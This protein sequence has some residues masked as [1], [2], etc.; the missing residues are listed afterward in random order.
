MAK[1]ACCVVVVLAA[2]ASLGAASECLLDGGEA[3]HDI[4]ETHVRY[5]LAPEAPSCCDEC[6]AQLAALEWV[7]ATLHSLWLHWDTARTQLAPESTAPRVL[8]VFGDRLKEMRVC[9]LLAEY[10][11]CLRRAMFW[12]ETLSCSPRAAA[13][14]EPRPGTAATNGTVRVCADVADEFFEECKHVQ[15]FGI[16][17]V[18][19]IYG[20][21]EDAAQKFYRVAVAGAQEGSKRIAGI[22]PTFVSAA[23]EAAGTTCLRPTEAEHAALDKEVGDAPLW[24]C[25]SFG[26]LPGC[27]YADFPPG[28]LERNATV[29]ALAAR[30]VC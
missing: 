15:I 23:D 5:G 30:G 8:D 4:T 20:G 17:T 21:V 27:E 13:F 28:V 16:T 25:D 3:L 12:V 24:C 11:R 22:E 19:G 7:N 29:D 9:S 10:P 14:F 6:A 18:G 1:R 26:R 2:V